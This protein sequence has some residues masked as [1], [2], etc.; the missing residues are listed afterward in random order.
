MSGDRIPAGENVFLRNFQSASGIKWAGPEAYHLPPSGAEVKNEWSY[1]SASPPPSY[2]C[3]VCRGETLPLEAHLPHMVT[4]IN[5]H[6]VAGKPV[7]KTL[8]TYVTVF[9]PV[10]RDSNLGREVILNWSRN[11]FINLLITNVRYHERCIKTVFV[12][13]C[14][15]L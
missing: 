10:G 9:Q 5:A 15:H 3:M 2:D 1:W 8:N 13:K 4:M 12:C 7:K 6:I 11:S 14:N